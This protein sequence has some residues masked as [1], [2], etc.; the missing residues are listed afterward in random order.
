MRLDRRRGK[1]M[2]M[3]VGIA[4]VAVLALVLVLATR[5]APD[6]NG[7]IPGNDVVA[8]VN[9]EEITAAEVAA[10]WTRLYE[11]HGTWL[12]PEQALEQL[13]TDRLLYW[14]AERE[15]FVPTIQEAEAM[16]TERLADDGIQAELFREMLAESGLSYQQFLEDLQVQMAITDFLDAVIE[17]PEVTDEE[18]REFY[19]YAKE[20]YWQLHPGQEPPSFEEMQARAVAILWDDRRNEA[21]N[22]LITELRAQADIVY[23]QSGL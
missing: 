22:L 8:T 12:A 6:S 13:I 20:Y 7:Q 14:E 5:E 23:V 15:G 1:T 4:A 9:G 17:V 16:L 2:G 3:V 18:V 21:I 19:E 10:M 11:A